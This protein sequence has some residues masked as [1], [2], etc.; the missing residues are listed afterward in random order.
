MPIMLKIKARP[1]ATSMNIDDKARILAIV[2]TISST[3]TLFSSGPGGAA[4]IRPD[5]FSL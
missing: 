3:F 2:P 4:R 5:R 1:S